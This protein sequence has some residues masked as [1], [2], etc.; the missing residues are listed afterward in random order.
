MVGM[1]LIAAV[2]LAGPLGYLARTRTRLPG[3]ALYLALWAVIF[4]IQTIVVHHE[5]A[6]DI[7]PLYFILNALILAFGI[8]LNHLG[9]RV[10]DRRRAGAAH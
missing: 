4:P 1:E 3:V 8:A 7:E 5:N 2:F 6:D 9:G 10:A